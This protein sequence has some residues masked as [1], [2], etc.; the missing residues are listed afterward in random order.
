MLDASAHRESLSMSETDIASFRPKSDFVRVM[1]ERGYIHQCSDLEALDK[2]AS[3]GIVTAYVGYDATATSL[4]IGNLISV[5]MLRRL[6]QTG[7]RPIVVMGGGTTKVGDPSGKDSQRQMLTPEKID[8]NQAFALTTPLLTTASGA[9]MGKTAAGAM[10]L[11]ADLMSPYDYWQFWRNVEDADVGRFMRLFTD[12]SLDEIARYE[13][14]QGA[15]IND[16]K[17]ALADAACALLHGADAAATAR[18][19]AQTT[20]EQGQVSADLP[21]VETPAAELDAGVPLAN[22]AETAGLAASRGEARRLAQGGGL[23]VNDVAWPDAGKLVTM[24]DVVDGTIKIA[25][26]KKKIVLIKPV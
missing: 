21:T 24:A 10:W 7:H 15:E 5:M 17:K 25:A 3:E 12:L 6:Q 20:F 13:A 8:A 9:K 11:N 23:R 16:A 19:T 14:L 18:A 4:H 2:A 22:L 26:G 1:Q